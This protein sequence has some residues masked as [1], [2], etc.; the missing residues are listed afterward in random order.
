MFSGLTATSSTEIASLTASVSTL[1]YDLVTA[2]AQAD[3]LVSELAAMSQTAKTAKA[4]LDAACQAADDQAARANALQ[5]AMIKADAVA[6][7]A[8]EAKR[9]LQSRVV[10]LEADLAAAGDLGELK[11]DLEADLASVQTTLVA[12]EA[13]FAA[14]R[15]SAADLQDQLDVS[16]AACMDAEAEISRLEM[17]DRERSASASETAADRQAALDQVEL[18]RDALR[19]EL[20]GL[21]AELRSAEQGHRRT[22]EAERESEAETA[23]LLAEATGKLAASEKAVVKLSAKLALKEEETKELAR[24]LME[25]PAAADP[26]PLPAPVAVDNTAR[27]SPDDGSLRLTEE[28]AEG[29]KRMENAISRLR[30]ERDGLRAEREE[31]QRSIR[32][33]VRLVPWSWPSPA[34]AADFSTVLLNRRPRLLR[35]RSTS[36][37]LREP[38]RTSSRSMRPSR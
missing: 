34:T 19:S 12:S 25:M 9:K 29:V 27:S 20:D 28:E 22:L 16:Q 14:A 1:T 17:V 13:S 2:R 38:S 3:T 15:S 32:F 18:E 23:T 5:E 30:G 33:S 37:L 21:R 11:N 36:P 7:E 35:L 26:A 24:A 8:E 6:A 31:L 10:A 4:D